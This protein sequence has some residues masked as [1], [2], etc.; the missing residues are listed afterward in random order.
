MDMEKLRHLGN[1]SLLD[2]NGISV[3]IMGILRMNKVSPFQ[4]SLG[5]IPGITQGFIISLSC[6]TAHVCLPDTSYK[7]QGAWSVFLLLE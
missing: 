5:I 7:V 2:L 3:G 4:Y 6:P 1:W